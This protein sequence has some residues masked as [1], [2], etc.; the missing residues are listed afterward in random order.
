VILYINWEILTPY[1]APDLPNP[2]AAFM[3]LSGPIPTSASDEQRYT[4]SWLDIIFIAYYIVFF[5]FVRQTITLKL[6]RPAARYF[7]LK[8]QAKID[9]FGEQGYALIYFAVMGIW[10]VVSSHVRLSEPQL[11]LN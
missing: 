9:R 4:K 2:F 10:G 3:F 6:C 1:V 11:L 5:S 7:G 8:K